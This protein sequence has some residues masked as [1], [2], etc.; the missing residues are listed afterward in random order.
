MMDVIVATSRWQ[1]TRPV[2]FVPLLAL[3]ALLA[4]YGVIEAGLAVMDRWDREIAQRMEAYRERVPETMVMRYE[5]RLRAVRAALTERGYK[6]GPLDGMMNARTAE[7]LRSFQRR[8]GLHV[9][10]RPDPATVAALGLV[11]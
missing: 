9:S 3:L 6:T 1:V 5:E 4:V 7:A 2:V 11:R 10:G 8:H